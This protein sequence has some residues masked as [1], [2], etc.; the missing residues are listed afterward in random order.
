MARMISTMT[1]ETA[2]PTSAMRWFIEWQELQRCK[3]V[4]EDGAPFASS[5]FDLDGPESRP[6]AAEQL[7]DL[8]TCDE[9]R[10]VA[11][12]D[13][14]EPFGIT[15]VL[16]KMAHTQFLFND[17][18][19]LEFDK[20]DQWWRVSGELKM[21]EVHEYALNTDTGKIEWRPPGPGVGVEH[22]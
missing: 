6:C 2:K 19:A 13:T 20:R 9:R 14:Y 7:M 18:S 15:G 8:M 4:H 5:Q 22:G 12:D 21:L 10:I 3:Y 1:S 16:D 11:D 17:G